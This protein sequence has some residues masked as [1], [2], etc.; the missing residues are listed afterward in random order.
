MGDK[1]KVLIINHVLSHNLHTIFVFT[2]NLLCLNKIRQYM[3]NCQGFHDFYI[4]YSKIL[5]NQ[6]QTK[7]TWNW[8]TENQN[9]NFI[10]KVRKHVTVRSTDVTVT[11]Y[12]EFWIFQF[13]NVGLYHVRETQEKHRCNSSWAYD[14]ISSI[15]S[16]FK[17][18]ILDK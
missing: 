3:R 18:V 1:Y 6:K 5:L 12:S 10:F 8:L 7:Q 4:I 15:P 14:D 16:S 17:L 13:N 11:Y 9:K 2:S